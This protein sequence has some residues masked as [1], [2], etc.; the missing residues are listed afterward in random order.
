MFSSSGAVIH[1]YAFQSAKNETATSGLVVCTFLRNPSTGTGE[2]ECAV[3]FRRNCWNAWQHSSDPLDCH[4]EDNLSLT[5]SI[6]ND[7]STRS[8]LV[9]GHPLW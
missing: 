2:R 8:A 5:A 4:D 6:E 7:T 3:D 1:S 9:A